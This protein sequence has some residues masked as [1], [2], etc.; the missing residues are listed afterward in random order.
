MGA[1][2]ITKDNEAVGQGNSPCK[3]C[4][5]SSITDGDTLESGFSKVN[6]VF[7]SGLGETQAI[8]WTQSDGTITFTVTAGPATNID[9]L[10]FGEF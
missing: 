3:R 9:L 1:V 10:I 8:A 2:T 7:A 4:T 5:A 6:Q